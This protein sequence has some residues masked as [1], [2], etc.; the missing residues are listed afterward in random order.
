MLEIKNLSVATNKSDILND[1]DLKIDDNKI[2]VIMGPNGTGKSTLCK[3][4]IGER[5]GLKVKGS[6]KYNN[7]E[8]INMPI[9]EIS[10]KGIFMLFQSPLEIPGVTPAEMLRIALKERNIDKSVFEFSKELNAICDKLNIDKKLLHRG[11][12]ERMSGGERKKMELLQVFV[13]KPS[14]ILLDELDSGLDVD[15]LKSLSKSLLE[16]KSENK[17]SIVIITHHMNILEFLK[18]DKVHILSDKKIS[19]SGDINLAKKIEKDGFNGTFN[20]I[21]EE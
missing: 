7:E 14:L 18:P 20:M 15:S 8:L 16:Y 10:K 11:I 17:C 6:I 13:L 21:E 2:H 9:N 5:D 1:L 19:K 4:I 3:T 12:N